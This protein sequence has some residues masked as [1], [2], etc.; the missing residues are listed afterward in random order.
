MNTNHRFRVFNCFRRAV[1]IIAWSNSLNLITKR[2][3]SELSRFAFSGVESFA[4]G[5]KS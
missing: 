5:R 3:A 1:T 4:I 2:V